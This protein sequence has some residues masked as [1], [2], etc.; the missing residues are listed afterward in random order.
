MNIFDIGTLNQNKKQASNM[1]W[2]HELAAWNSGAWSR[3][4]SEP[5]FNDSVQFEDGSCTRKQ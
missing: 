4:L 2:P 3:L 1:R 5:A